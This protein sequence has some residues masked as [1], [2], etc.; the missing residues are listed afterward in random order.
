MDDV[1]LPLGG[2]EVDGQLDALGLVHSERKVG[3][4]L[5]ILETET[6]EVLFGERLGVQDTGS[7]GL[8]V[9]AALGG[10]RVVCVLLG[11]VMLAR[12]AQIC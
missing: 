11:G 7:G 1:L 5:Q 12:A 2:V 6:L 10:A 9:F 3:L 8:V 4:L